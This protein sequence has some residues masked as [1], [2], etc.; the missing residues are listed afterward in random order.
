MAPM[1]QAAVCQTTTSCVKMAQ[2]CLAPGAGC[3]CFTP[4]WP[5]KPS[6]A[7]PWHRIR[8]RS[9]G[10][11]WVVDCTVLLTEVAVVSRMWLLRLGSWGNDY[12]LRQARAA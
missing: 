6:M 12:N 3:R 11:V 10:A 8:Y 5:F 4:L 9:R 1:M 2:S 7:Y